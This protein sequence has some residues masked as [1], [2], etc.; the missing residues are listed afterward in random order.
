MFHG[1]FTQTGHRAG[2]HLDVTLRV[3]LWFICCSS[4]FWENIVKNHNIYPLSS[5]VSPLDFFETTSTMRNS[6]SLKRF[7]HWIAL[8]IIGKEYGF[9]HWTWFLIIGDLVDV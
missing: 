8:V 5:S 2:L 1:A 7:P 4:V 6:Q 9:F 3:L